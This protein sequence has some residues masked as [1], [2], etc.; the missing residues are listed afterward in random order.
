MKVSVGLVRDPKDRD[1]AHGLFVPIPHTAHRP[2]TSYRV[3]IRDRN[4]VLRARRAGLPLH[5]IGPEVTAAWGFPGSSQDLLVLAKEVVDLVDTDFAVAL[6]ESSAA[7]RS[8]RLEDLVVVLLQRDPLLARA[9]AL[10]HRRFL[11]PQRLLKRLLQEN[12]E[13]AATLV[14]LQAIVPGLPREGET[15]PAAALVRQDSNSWVEGRL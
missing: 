7:A 15:L 11:N 14:G 8:P 3:R 9:F 1:L 2:R 5:F 6:L 12:Q 4:D 10:R 13:Q